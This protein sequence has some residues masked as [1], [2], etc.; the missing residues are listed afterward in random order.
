MSRQPTDSDQ[1]VSAV[2]QGVDLAD[3]GTPATL[4]QLL[5]ASKRWAQHATRLGWI[6]EAARDSVAELPAAMS[7]D[8]FDPEEQTPLVVALFGGTGVGKSSLLNALVGKE[9]AKVGVIR[10][11]SLEATAYVHADIHFNTPARFLRAAHNDDRRRHLVWVDM[12]DIDSTAVANRELV[13]DF[14]PYVDLLVYVVSPERYRDEAPWALLRE[15]VQTTAWVFVMNQMDRGTTAQFDDLRTVLGEAGFTD[16]ILLRTSAL[17]GATAVDE[18]NEIDAL[19]ERIDELSEARLR[20]VIQDQAR[21]ARRE[22][23]AARLIEITRTWPT[24]TEIVW[25]AWEQGRARLQRE[26]ESDL[27][28][29]LAPVAARMVDGQPVAEGELWDQWSSERFTDALSQTALEAAAHTWPVAVLEPLRTLSVSDLATQAEEVLRRSVR[30]SLAQPG[31]A[32][33]RAVHA[34][35]EKLIYLLPLAALGWVGW[36]VLSGFYQGTQGGGRGIEGGGGFVGEGFAV[37]AVLLVILAAVAPYLGAR[38]AKPSPKRAALRGIQVGLQELI[39]LL[40]NQANSAIDQ[41]EHGLTELRQESAA[42][43]QQLGVSDTRVAVAGAPSEG[44]TLSADGD[45]RADPRR[46]PGRSSGAAAEAAGRLADSNAHELAVRL[47]SKKTTPSLSQP[48]KQN[49]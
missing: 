12:P 39:G 8:L 37:N 14:L 3:T 1:P 27:V 24:D 34:G 7:A 29:R 2:R 6:D 46:D 9:I 18:G 16:P 35:L 47:R 13:L 20:H 49:D 42:I 38:L 44:T 25:R 10:P 22:Q 15:H 48:S 33:Q 32:I 43:V 21:S 19:R 5:D 45:V 31:S 4:A 40:D 30:Q 11:T 36:H 28:A 41:L 26:L 23:L 17:S